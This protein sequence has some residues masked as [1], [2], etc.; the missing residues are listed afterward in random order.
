[1]VYDFESTE[2]RIILYIHKDLYFNRMNHNL[3]P[4]FIMILDGLEVD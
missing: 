4:P 1:M 2:R 3:I